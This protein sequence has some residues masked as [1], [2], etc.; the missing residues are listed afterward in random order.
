MPCCLREMKVIGLDENGDEFFDPQGLVNHF[1]LSV[2]N[3]SQ[4]F[5]VVEESTKK[6]YDQFGN[7]GSGFESEGLVECCLI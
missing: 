5:P 4:W 7:S 3:D 1:L 6:C 2:G